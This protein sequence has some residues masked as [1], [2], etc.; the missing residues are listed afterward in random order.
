MPAVGVTARRAAR[1]LIR[2]LSWICLVD[3]SVCSLAASKLINQD[4]TDAITCL[5]AARRRTKRG[6]TVCTA[7]TKTVSDIADMHKQVSVLCR[8]AQS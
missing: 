1:R 7:C 6:K 8:D 4:Q 3:Q 5:G 2:D